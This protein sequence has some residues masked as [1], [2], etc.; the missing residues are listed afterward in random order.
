MP[1]K[2]KAT[3]ETPQPRRKSARL[4]PA[5]EPEPPE[6]WPELARLAKERIN[7]YASASSKKARKGD[8]KLKPCMIA[9][10]DWLPEEGRES[11]AHDMLKSITDDML[12]DMFQNIRTCLLFPSKFTAG[13]S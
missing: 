4:N 10:L 9:L 12:Y 5:V 3:L 13:H 6:T 2:R 1:P 8:E 11:A 7:R